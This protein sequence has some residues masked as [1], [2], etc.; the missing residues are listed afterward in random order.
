M[1]N[2]LRGLPTTVVPWARTV[3]DRVRGAER[4][5]ARLGYNVASMPDADKTVYS[6]Y[7]LGQNI[8][9]GTTGKVALNTPVLV[10]YVSS[11]GLFEVTVSLAGLV[12][13]GATLGASFESNENPYSV[14]Y[15]IPQYGVVAQAPA[16][17]TTWKPFSASYSTVVST[18]PGGQ[19][20]SMYL[21]AICTTGANSAAFV[22]RARLSVKAV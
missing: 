15:D 12:R 13:D 2:N 5:L 21:Y 20:L 10:H 1:A 17:Q 7:S 6:E 18:R 3:E 22:K 8:A 16:G 4:F 14:E 11:T 9:V 19:D